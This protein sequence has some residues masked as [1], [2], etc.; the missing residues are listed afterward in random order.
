MPLIY[1]T[2]HIAI[3][4]SNYERSKLFYTQLLGLEVIH[5]TF[6][7]DRNS[8]KLDLR[9]PDGTQIELF[10]FPN[11]PPRVSRPEASGLRHLAF[12]VLNLEATITALSPHGIELEPIRVDEFT[13]KRFTFI[14]DPDG[15]PLELYETSNASLEKSERSDSL[16]VQTFIADLGILNEVAL[17]ESPWKV[18]SNLKLIISNELARLSEQACRDLNI[19]IHPDAIVESGATIKGPCYI[20]AG[21]FVAAGSYL[22]GGVFLDSQV[23][24]G[25]GCE[26]KSSIVGKKSCLAHF[27]FIGDSIIGSDV[28]FEAGAHTANHWNDR[29]DKT[30]YVARDR[31]AIRI[32]T[33]KFGAVA[34]DGS[35]IGAN[36]V[37]SPGTL[38][39]KNSKVPR[40]IALR[41]NPGSI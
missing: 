19:F 7:K 11:P 18:L 24:V 10:S 26:V 34:G 8:F 35:R 4:C 16:C 31:G 37:L 32:D 2:H 17:K 29:D 38:L 14:V 28:N 5:E 12:R 25:P 30:I 9:M 3:I 36:S 1:G 6:R 33:E 40:R 27:N 22:R 13:N 21:C 20:S 39:P 41:L 23:S 15:L